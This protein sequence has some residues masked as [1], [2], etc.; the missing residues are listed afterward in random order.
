MFPTSI[1]LH[2]CGADTVRKVFITLRPYLPIR[3]KPYKLR[4]S[5]NLDNAVDKVCIRGVISDDLC[6]IKLT[7]QH[8]FTSPL[9]IM[10]K[11]SCSQFDTAVGYSSVDVDLKTLYGDNNPFW[12]HY[13]FPKLK[14]FYKQC[15]REPRT[16][17]AF[18]HSKYIFA[19]HK[20][21]YI[22]TTNMSMHYEG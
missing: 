18:C 1:N 8:S 7:D 17:W 13:R 15:P 12:Q 6:E 19:N 5:G 22:Y 10:V 3:M 9:R 14:V 20:T 16:F 4:I 2:E 21:I 11:T